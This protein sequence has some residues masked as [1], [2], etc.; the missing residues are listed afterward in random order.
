M[1]SQDASESAPASGMPPASA[2]DLQTHLLAASDDLERLQCLL[3]DASHAL[4]GRYTGAL[5]QIDAAVHDLAAARAGEPEAMDKARRTLDGAITALQFQDM[6]AQ[7][8]SH[9][10][11]RLRSCADRLAGDGTNDDAVATGAGQPR[12]RAG[13]VIQD[14]LRAGSVELF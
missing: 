5:L 1:L 7:L 14:G 12:R 3:A 10:T 8:I 2:A 9:A 13:P 4:I 6:A 11:Q